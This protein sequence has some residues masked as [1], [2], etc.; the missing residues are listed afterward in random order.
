[1]GWFVRELLLLSM[2]TVWMKMKASGMD[3]GGL[4]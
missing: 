4:I 2:M 1:M 3:R